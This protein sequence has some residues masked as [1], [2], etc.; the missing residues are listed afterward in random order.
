MRSMSFRVFLF[1]A[2]AILGT[3]AFAHDI[4]I[5]G[6]QNFS[7][8]DGS[9]S[10]HD[11]I[12]NGVFTVSDGNLIVNGI[13]NCND[14]IGH[15]CLRDVVRGERQHDRQ[16]RRRALRREPQ[17]QRHRRRDH[18]HR[19]RQ[20]RPQR[21]RHR[22]SGVDD[23]NGS[24]TAARSPR[25]SPAASRW[26]PARRIDSGA[27]NAAGRRDRR[28]RGRRGQRR[29][30]TCSPAPSRTLLATRLTGAALD[31]GTGNQSAAR[32]PSAPPR[33]SSRPSSSAPTANIVSQGEKNGAGPVTI[34]GC[35][36]QVR[37]PRGR[38]LAQG[39]ARERRE[40]PLR[41]RHPHRR[42]RPRRRR[43]RAWAACAPTRSTR[44]GRQQRR[45]RLRR[46]DHRASS[47]RRARSSPSRAIPGLHDSRATAALIRVISARRR[48]QRHPAT[49]IDGRPHRHGDTGG[50]VEISRRRAT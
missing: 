40:H 35:G 37:R 31:G 27:A 7:S 10:D 24:R 23:S 38:A 5:S 39:P 30:A 50:T 11:G 21:Q 36:V 12:V 34:D 46:R 19:R 3:S 2:V 48:G 16:L 14:D 32:S 41:Q 18:P 26:P 1:L 44:H 28:R 13:V 25:T 22:L 47:V 4:T 49:R 6:T 29:T 20:P 9:S 17:R 45:R 8:L 15:Q 33:S 42:P 43:H